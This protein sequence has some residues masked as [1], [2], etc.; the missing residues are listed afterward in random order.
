MCVNSQVRSYQPVII[1]G[2]GRSG[3]NM[4]RDV[5]SQ[6]P[7]FGT[8][9]CDEINYI[10]RHGNVR[11]P[12]DEFSS[13]LATKPVKAFIRK[14]F[15]QIAEKQRLSYLVEKT[16][17]NSLRV[18]FVNQVIPQAKFIHIIRDGRDVVASA[19]K[20]WI[21]TLDIPYILKKA[22]FV[23]RSDFPYYAFRYLGNR[24]Y[25]LI[26]R[27]NRLAFWGPRFEGMD[28]ALKQYSLAE[29][30]AIQ[31]QLCVEKS[32][33]EFKQ[34]DSSRI[35]QLCYEDFVANPTRELLGIGSFLEVGISEQKA[36]AL[37]QNVSAKSVGRWKRD[38]NKNTLMLIDTLMQNTLN[39][40][41]YF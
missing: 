14:A 4:L 23:P 18:G 28:K 3:T 33:L 39:K 27:E 34:L 29:V 36:L 31:W 20:R 35:Y 8:W 6:L 15:D 38:L 37:V 30:C 9:P 19:Q 22:R 5:L 26:S 17:A 2:A 41:G 12:T 11:E 32:E 13:E 24:I 21:A 16:C 25:R 40:Y 7:G 1:I 10:W